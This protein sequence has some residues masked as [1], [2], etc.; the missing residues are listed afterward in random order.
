MS[1]CIIVDHVSKGFKTYSTPGSRFKEWFLPGNH[2][3]HKTKWVLQDINFSVE[4]GEAVGI[5]G[6]NG[7]GKSTLLKIIT[8]TTAATKGSVTVT[9]NVSALLELGLGFHPDFTGRQNVY[10]S[11]QLMGY[12]IEEINECMKDVEAFAD[13]GNAIEEPVRTYS[14]GMA[15]RL[16]FAV[17]TM[18]RPQILIVDEAL[19]VGDLFFQA[20]CFARIKDF[21]EHGTTLLFVS[22]AASDMVR[23]CK[24]VIYLKNGHL[25][26]DGEARDV[27]NAYLDD[28]FGKRRLSVSSLGKD[29]KS[30]DDSCKIEDKKDK[31]FLA[32]HI[33]NANWAKND[34]YSTRP[35][36]RKEEYR[37]GMGGAKILDYKILQ[38]GEEY[39]TVL[40][41]GKRLTLKYQVIFERDVMRP[42][43]GIL[44]KTHD[45]LNIYGTNSEISGSMMPDQICVKT[46]DMIEITFDF[47]NNL[48]AGAYLFSFGVTDMSMGSPG[49]PMDRRYDSVLM[50]VVNNNPI[51]GIVDFHSTFDMTRRY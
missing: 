49:E 41:T 24:R 40:Y 45:G 27:T 25:F 48:S 8:G 6:V 42:V 30:N 19:A 39:P 46:G 29:N 9:G 12:S 34:V 22:H 38:D 5:V 1:K 17:A 51:T 2:Q 33:N 31:F 10:M 4:Q 28:L 20:K 3:N 35:F 43:Y 26:M 15:V 16:A 11:G 14:S 50:R 13:I 32:N 7:A 37:W 44:I 18:K 23:Y 21:Q 36:Y 47:T